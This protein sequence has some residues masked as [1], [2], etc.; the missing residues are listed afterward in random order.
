MPLGVSP[1]PNR[2]TA[3]ITGIQYRTLTPVTV[4][5]TTAGGVGTMTAAQCLSGLLRVDC[6][7]AQSLTFPTA[8]QIIAAMPG[9]EVG[10]T[11]ELTIINFGDTTL[12]MVV[13][14]GMTNFTIGAVKAIMTLATFVSKKFT[15]R[16][17]GIAAQGGTDAVELYGHGSTTLAVG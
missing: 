11:F 13:G 16:V 8:A 15:I 1:S 17:T 14:A 9:P 5:L 10:S 4:T 3:Y 12:T 6:Q 7:D 2:S